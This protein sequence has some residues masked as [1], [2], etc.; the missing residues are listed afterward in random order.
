M[1][2]ETAEPIISQMHIRPDVLSIS[3]CEENQRWRLSVPA[4]A[5]AGCPAL[6]SKANQFGCRLVV[7]RDPAEYPE[8]TINEILDVWLDS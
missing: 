3:W 8:F 5:F 4:C 7:L 6:T 1:T 2:D